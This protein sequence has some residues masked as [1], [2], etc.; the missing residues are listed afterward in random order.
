MGNNEPQILPIDHLR[1]LAR[2][3]RMAQSVEAVTADAPFAC[4]LLWQRIGSGG[5]GQ[6]CVESSVECCHLWN[7]WQNLLHH[8]N[9]LQA[10][11]V[12]ER[13]QLSQVFDRPFNLSRDPDGGGEALA[14]MDNAMSHGPDVFKRGQS[15]RWA[16]VQI[17]EN[18]SGGV[19]VFLQLQFLADFRLACPAEN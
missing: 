12:V 13:S 17:V 6:G 8:V 7:L 16:S 11:W 19:S 14:A 1:R 9:A 2:A 18:S 10:G 3:V 15:G 4:P 5:L